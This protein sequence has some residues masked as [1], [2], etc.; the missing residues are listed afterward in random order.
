MSVSSYIP[1]TPL[2]LPYIHY[3]QRAKDGTQVPISLV[4]RPSALPGS[5]TASP[6]SSPPPL[7]LYGYGEWELIDA[8][9]ASTGS[10]L[11]SVTAS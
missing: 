5:T 11:C 7:L 1:L 6:P 8:A 2:S 9:A 10:V 4:W 3:V